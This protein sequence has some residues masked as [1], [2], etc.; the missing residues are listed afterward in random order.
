MAPRGQAAPGEGGG[1]C[2]AQMY[3]VATA[4][5]LS[6]HRGV[7]RWASYVYEETLVSVTCRPIFVFHAR[8]LIAVG[9][10][11]ARE[12]L[13]NFSLV[14]TF[15]GATRHVVIGETPVAIVECT[16]NNPYSADVV[17]CLLESGLS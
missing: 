8:G 4:F 12:T 16:T 17:Q 1:R 7:P 9:Q 14:G 10:R 15:S 11:L 2:R 3:G 6:A 13:V 5:S